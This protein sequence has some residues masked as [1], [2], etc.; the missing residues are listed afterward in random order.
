MSGSPPYDEAGP[1]PSFLTERRAM[2]IAVLVALLY[3]AI[4]WQSAPAMGFTRDEG[5]YFKAADEYSGWWGT[6]FSRRFFAAFSDDEIKRFMSYNTEHPASVKIFFGVT[7]AFFH[8]LLGVAS[9]TQGYRAGG[10]I[11]AA[12]SLF[13]TFL[14][15]RL[16]VNKEVGLL[17]MLLLA[18]IP[19]YFYD[20]H[21]ACFDVP[22]TALWALSLWGFW[23]AFIAM[24]S[25][26]GR[27]RK[28]LVAGLI[29]GWGL[30]TKLNALFLPVVFVFV[31]LWTFPF[32]Q[33]RFSRGPSGGR[34]LVLP[35]IPWV[36]ISCAIV[37]PIV[38][39][40][41]WPYTWHD[42]IGRI[43]GYIAFHLH[44]E[45]YPIAY[46]H[47]ILIK[48]PFPTEFPFVMT[49]FTA[50]LPLIVLGTF[51]L[52]VSLWR[53]F[54]RRSGDDALLFAATMLPFILLTLPS[55]PIFGGVK[56]WYNA[57]PTLCIVAARAG[58]DG[59]RAIALRWPRQTPVLVTA[60]LALC[61][62]PGALG[63]ARSHPYGIGYYNEVAGGFRGGAELGMQRTFWGGA[64]GDLMPKI[65]ELKGPSMVYFH[66][67]NYD[68][69]RFYERDGRLPPNVYYANDPK[70][71]LAA[72]VSYAMPE[73]EEKEGEVW[74]MLGTKPVMGTYQHNVWM[75]Q[76]YVKD[77]KLSP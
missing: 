48:P 45:H 37:G 17:A 43:G 15:G 70:G 74:S 38:F 21:L 73:F 9:H 52:V 7:H 18:T 2:L 13:A 25:A 34:D 77:G 3:A 46:F 28:A 12:L 50:P 6:V 57:M 10:F 41:M 39:Y 62:L 19:R 60:M 20:A 68:A 58:I 65:A 8:D 47:Q 22:I 31:W 36:L 1:G 26:H 51:G 59:A 76:L 23:R 54:W 69:Y 27:K 42:P 33:I 67:T 75:T 14:L 11:F 55:T 56:H 29:F 61:L 16:L 44:H 71:D 24:S 4:L 66:E 53:M 5:Y 30:A 35:A 64:T 49:L 40:L 63:I 72:G 32:G